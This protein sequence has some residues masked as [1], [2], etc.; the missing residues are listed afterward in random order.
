MRSYTGTRVDDFLEGWDFKDELHPGDVITYTSPIFVYGNPQG[1]RIATVLCTDP[2]RD[3]YWLSIEP[4][5]ALPNDT[6]VKRVGKIVSD[7]GTFIA[8]DGGRP[9]E[10]EEY[11]MKKEGDRVSAVRKALSAGGDYIQTTL[12][13]RVQEMMHSIQRTNG[14]MLEDIFIVAPGENSNAAAAA[15]SNASNFIVPPG[16]NSNAAAAATKSNA[17]NFIIPPGKNSN[18]A[19]AA[20]KS[21][22]SKNS[23]TGTKSSAANEA[24]AANIVQD[25]RKKGASPHTGIPADEISLLPRNNMGLS[26]MPFVSPDSLSHNVWDTDMN[27]G[28]PIMPSLNPTSPTMLQMQQMQLWQQMQQ[29]M[30]QFQMHPFVAA[31]CAQGP[32]VLSHATGS[33]PVAAR[34]NSKRPLTENS[35]TTQSKKA[36]KKQPYKKPV[37][38]QPLKGKV[39]NGRARGSVKWTDEEMNRLMTACEA[40]DYPASAKD[41]RQV[42]ITFDALCDEP[43]LLNERSSVALQ[44]KFE[45]IANK[46]DDDPD[47][48]VFVKRINKMKED[49][50]KKG[51]I[52]STASPIGFAIDDGESDSP[53]TALVWKKYLAAVQKKKEAEEEERKERDTMNT[54]L[55][56]VND[57]LSGMTNDSGGNV[58]MV[59]LQH[60]QEDLEAKMGQMEATMNEMKMGMDAGF[61]EILKRMQNN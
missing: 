49:E 53:D 54:I 35:S 47:F 12:K 33:E 7:N 58:A 50:A 9:M 31:Q 34:P 4:Y 57:A 41:W 32:A 2:T 56:S 55:S 27:T 6:R 38:S 14:M 46:S 48:G 30:Q 8:H 22:A 19:A 11:E 61:N 18:A 24:S 1:L 21:N 26:S 15:K 37:K 42:K 60:K 36:A 5:E 23:N 20:T 44:N 43:S 40:T 52:R 45:I 28:A 29:Q 3:E 51:S 59:N 17:S 10:I 25:T 16:K 13:R 39:S